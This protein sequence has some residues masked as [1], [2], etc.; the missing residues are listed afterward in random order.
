MNFRC[1]LETMSGT[2]NLA[3][4]LVLVS[5]GYWGRIYNL[6]FTKL[7]SSLTTYKHLSLNPHFPLIK[8]SS[9]YSRW[10][11]PQKTTANQTA[12]LWSLVQS[13]G[14]HRQTLPHLRLREHC[15]RWAKDGKNQRAREFA[16]RL[17]LLVTSETTS[18]KSDQYDH[19]HVIQTCMTPMDSPRW[20]EGPQPDVKN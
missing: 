20:T 18:I 10:T 7:M 8:E 1:P 12:E 2:G 16:M 4:Y 5:H 11:A 9:L 17:F 13:Q 3:N 14:T 15:R 19:P 6:Q